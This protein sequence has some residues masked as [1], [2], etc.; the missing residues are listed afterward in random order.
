MV[1]CVHVCV[2]M[3]L[4]VHVHVCACSCVYIRLSVCMFVCVHVYTCS[5]VCM[6]LSVH[7]PMCT[8]SCVCMFMYVHVCG[9]Q[10]L[11]FIFSL[12]HDLFLKLEL[13]DWLGWL[14]SELQKIPAPPSTLC[15]QNLIFKM[16]GNFYL[17]TWSIHVAHAC[18]HST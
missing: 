10:K 6:L 14:I 4:C 13:T 2:C 12:R 11:I 1:L 16:E 15:S 18:N 3:I 17:E 7:A 5:C 8:C 9:G